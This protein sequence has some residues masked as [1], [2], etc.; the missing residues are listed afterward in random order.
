MEYQQSVGYEILRKMEQYKGA[1]VPSPY[2]PLDPDT[3]LP[4][5][6]EI[7]PAPAITPRGGPK[8]ER[9]VAPDT[10]DPQSW[11]GEMSVALFLQHTAWLKEEG[12]ITTKPDVVLAG[13]HPKALK[14]KAVRFLK[15]VDN[16]GGWEESLAIAKESGALDTLSDTMDA[17][18]KAGQRNE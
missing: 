6:H 2:Q 5:C 11:V 9:P 10:T 4:T 18:L 15:A 14:Y 12:F 7:P 17:L 8:I 1:E 16:A 13:D 3:G